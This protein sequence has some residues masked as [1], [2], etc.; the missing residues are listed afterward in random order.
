MTKQDE[1]YFLKPS[2]RN[3]LEGNCFL[4]ER[5]RWFKCKIHFSLF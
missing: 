4:S 5:T 1:G 3:F 2:L